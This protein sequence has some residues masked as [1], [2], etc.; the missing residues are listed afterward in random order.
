MRHCTIRNRNFIER[1][2][3]KLKLDKSLYFAEKG[4]RNEANCENRSSFRSI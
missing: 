4:K 1:F 2:E 3:K